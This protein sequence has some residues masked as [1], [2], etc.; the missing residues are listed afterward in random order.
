[1]EDNNIKNNNQEDYLP[2]REDKLEK[3]LEQNLEVSLE[4]LR[5][6]KYIRKYVFWQKFFN[7]FKIILILAPIILAFI[8]LPPFL[9]SLNFNIQ[10]IFDGLNIVT[11]PSAIEEVLGK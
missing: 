2:S 10:T 4:I 7:W 5:L 1:M 9:K 8:Y 6:S 11:N 3:L